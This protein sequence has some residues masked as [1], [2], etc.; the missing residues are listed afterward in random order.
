MVWY[1]VRPMIAITMCYQPHLLCCKVD[2]SNVIGDSTLLSQIFYEFLDSGT[3][4]GMA[5]RQRQI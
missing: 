1:E 4:Q 2:P 3:A 5:D